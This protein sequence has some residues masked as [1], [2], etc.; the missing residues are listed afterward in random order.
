MK[1]YSLGLVYI[2]KLEQF[3]DRISYCKILGLSEHNRRVNHVE[4]KGPNND[5]PVI[6]FYIFNDPYI[7]DGTIGFA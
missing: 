6:S 7:E 5:D 2:I 3:L 1:Y 4:L